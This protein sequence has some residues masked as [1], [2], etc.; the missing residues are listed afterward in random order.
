MEENLDKM[1]EVIALFE[2]RTFYGYTIN[3]FGGN[4]GNALPE[5]KYHSSWDW[6]LPV[7]YKFIDLRFADVMHQLKHSELKS[8]IG[9]AILYGGIELAHKNIF[10]GIQW[11]KTTIK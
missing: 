8:I 9:L 1:N 5:M 7:W 2:G 10:E 6:L 4:T 11:Y 3:K